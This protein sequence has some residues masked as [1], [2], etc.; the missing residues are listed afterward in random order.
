MLKALTIRLLV[1]LVVACLLVIAA[2]S[3]KYLLNRPPV[4]KPP[5][6]LAFDLPHRRPSPTPPPHGTILDTAWCDDERAVLGW[7]SDG[8]AWVWRGT[9]KQ[10]EQLCAEAED[11]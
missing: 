2:A 6:G 5:E 1:T 7:V 10:L 11:E 8:V 9:P 4:G 3:I